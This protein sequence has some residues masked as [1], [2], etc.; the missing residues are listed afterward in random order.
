MFPTNLFFQLHLRQTSE[1][2]RR[3]TKEA[4]REFIA[5][6]NSKFEK[7]RAAGRR[8]KVYYTCGTN[9]AGKKTFTGGKDLQSTSCY[10]KRFAHAIFAVSG[11]NLTKLPPAMIRRANKIMVHPAVIETRFGADPLKLRCHF[12]SSY[13]S[14]CCL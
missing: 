8:A 3:A 2:A 7:R 4:K 9:E 13:V 1:L 11:I 6:V 12:I 14:K 5:R 10:P